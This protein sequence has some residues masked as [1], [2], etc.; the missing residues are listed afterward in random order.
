M[1]RYIMLC[2]ILAIC[3][4]CMGCNKEKPFE[5]E[6]ED[7]RAY[8]TLSDEMAKEVETLKPNYSGIVDSVEVIKA[9]PFD[10]LE[11]MQH[12]MLSGEFS[13]LTLQQLYYAFDRDEK[14]R[15]IIPDLRQVY[16]PVGPISMEI[17]LVFLYPNGYRARLE[18]SADG[19][20]YKA[21]WLNDGFFEEYFYSRYQSEIDAR[22]SSGYT[23]EYDEKGGEIR[24]YLTPSEEVNKLVVYTVTNENGTYWIVEKYKS[25]ILNSQYLLAQTKNGN[26]VLSVNSRTPC[27]W[28]FLL[29]IGIE[30]IES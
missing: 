19:V 5:I 25:N 1:K 13:S 24:T 15:F 28:D 30:K 7:G 23:T 16:R 8:L 20:K 14:G 27:D 17:G 18:W 12:E 2:L 11:E 4:G 26:Y 6:Y 29:S 21:T 22:E 3:I 10:T 9:I